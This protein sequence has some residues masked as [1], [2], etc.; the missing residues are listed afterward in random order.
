MPNSNV[1]VFDLGKVLVDCDYSVA[2]RKMAAQ[3]VL[4]TDEITLNRA[5]AVRREL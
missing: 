4:G 2:S 1:V 3:S 5:M